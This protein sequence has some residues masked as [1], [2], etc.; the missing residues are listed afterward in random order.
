[1]AYSKIR[2]QRIAAAKL[3][4]R[5]LPF[6]WKEM[7]VFFNNTCVKC[8][9]ETKN[10][11]IEKD[12]II[13]IYLGGSDSIQNLQPLCHICNT[14]KGSEC[15]DWRLKYCIDLELEMPVKWLPYGKTVNPN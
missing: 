10:T 15:K 9:G 13:P 8:K 4:G 2:T 11:W 12:H 3:K 5:H 6:E 14:S 7:K 1:M